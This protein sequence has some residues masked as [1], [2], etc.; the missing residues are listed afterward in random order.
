M[1]SRLRKFKAQLGIS[2]TKVK[3]KKHTPFL[4]QNINPTLFRVPILPQNFDT[5]ES[6]LSPKCMRDN[7]VENPVEAFKKLVDIQETFRDESLTLP[8][9]RAKT[10]SDDFAKLFKQLKSNLVEM[11][12]IQ[13][14]EDNHIAL[15]EIQMFVINIEQT[16]SA[17]LCC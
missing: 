10:S 16:R 1:I 8:N 14:I 4:L 11:D 13:T 7:Q 17:Q 15:F 5:F 3:R 2:L 6:N 12:L 9:A